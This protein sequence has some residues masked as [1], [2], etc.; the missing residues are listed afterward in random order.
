MELMIYVA[1]EAI[2]MNDNVVSENEKA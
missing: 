1:N 2:M